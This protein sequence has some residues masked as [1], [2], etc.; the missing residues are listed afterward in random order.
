MR[1]IG[2]CSTER[3]RE[4][5]PQLNAFVA[6]PRHVLRR[7]QLCSNNQLEPVRRFVG[8]FDNDTELRDEFRARPRVASGAIVRGHGRR[9]FCQLSS[10]DI[11]GNRSR[12]LV[13]Q[14]QHLGRK[15]HR[16]LFEFFAL[17]AHGATRKH[18][19]YQRLSAN[20]QIAN[21]QI[22]R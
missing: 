14:P 21:D 11:A 7:K 9:T 20:N 10:N 16:A 15:P 13:D 3:F 22:T 1:S 17:T 18:V 5:R 19:A 12:K 6:C 4:D 8:L 2:S